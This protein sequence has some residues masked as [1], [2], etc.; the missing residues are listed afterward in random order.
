MVVAEG[1]G[2]SSDAPAAVVRQ[3]NLKAECAV[4]VT[5][6]AILQKF[7]EGAA[8]RPNP[9]RVVLVLLSVWEPSWGKWW[10]TKKKAAPREMLVSGGAAQSV[11]C[12]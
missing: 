4:A 7:N 11:P 12:G 2:R 6:C 10:G 3:E 9:F 5:R 8:N 1:I